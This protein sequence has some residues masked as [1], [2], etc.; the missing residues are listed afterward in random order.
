[1]IL[2]RVL[3]GVSVGLTA[4][5]ASAAL[6]EFEPSGDRR[7]AAQWITVITALGVGVGP[8]YAGILVQYGPDTLTLSFWVL[9]ALLLA[10]LPATLII[11]EKPHD[12]ALPPPRAV[13]VFQI[14]TEIRAVFLLSALAAFVGFA[15]AGIFSGLAPSFLRDDLGITNH[16]FGGATVLL[17]F[18]SAAVAQLTLAGWDRHKVVRAGAVLAPLGLAAIA[19]AVWTG[20]AAPFFLGTI[21]C[22]VGFGL[23]L[24]GGLGLLNFVA[25]PDRRGEVLSAFYVAA[26]L[27]LSVPVVGIGVLATSFGLPTAVVVFSVLISLVSLTVIFSKELG[28][29]S[30]PSTP[31]EERSSAS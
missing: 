25:P 5:T 24:M 16:A 21:L 29:K 31:R 8:F 13:R 28:G 11:R 26:Y 23:S 18:G 12:R 19:T 17:M 14:P 27:G 1:M 7:R 2:A 3:S 6:T 4:S 20:F 10:A 30:E 15:L 22:G 9:L